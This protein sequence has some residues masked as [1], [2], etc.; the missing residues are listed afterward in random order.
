M[1]AITPT[2][3]TH[4]ESTTT[5]TINSQWKHKPIPRNPNLNFKRKTKKT[6]KKKQQKKKKQKQN[7][8]IQTKLEP[9]PTTTT[10]IAT[11]NHT[12]STHYCHPPPHILEPTIARPGNHK[13]NW[14]PNLPTQIQI[15]NHWPKPLPWPPIHTLEDAVAR[16]QRERERESK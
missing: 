3:H 16:S 15:Q 10:T 11:H 2:A 14:N 4:L 13:I 8:P 7:K 9:Q 5:T 12:K 1:E 6:K